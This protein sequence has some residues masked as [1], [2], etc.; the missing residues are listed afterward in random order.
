MIDLIKQIHCIED[1]YNEGLITGHQAI[2]KIV[3][4][5]VLKLDA[6]I[7]AREEKIQVTH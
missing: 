4:C 1:Q 7:E 5:S 6:L 2:V 3:E